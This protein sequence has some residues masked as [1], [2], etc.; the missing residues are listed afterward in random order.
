MTSATVRKARTS[1]QSIEA[2]HQEAERCLRA[3]DSA[4]A[5]RSNA[6]VLSTDPENIIALN[7]QGIIRA[8]Q[9]RLDEAAAAFEQ[10]L[11]VDPTAINAKQ[12]LDQIA[13][14]RAT[15][16]ASIA[17]A[18]DLLRDLTEQA[19][20]ATLDSA[21]ALHVMQE[22][23]SLSKRLAQAN[24]R[25]CI[26]A[27]RI[28]L[29]VQPNLLHGQIDLNNC[30]LKF[31]EKARL[32]DFS[33][34][35][36]P[37]QLGRH[38]LVACF[39]KSGSTLLKRLLCETTGFQEGQYCFAFLQNEQEIYL[40]LVLESA[41]EDRVIQQHCRATVPNLHIL[42]AFE[43]KPIVLVRNIFD[44]LLSWK[45]FL[46]KGAHVNTFFP[47][48]GELTEEQRL[49]LVVDDRA[50]WYL[51]FFAGWQH[52]VTSG[53]IEAT[54]MTYREL[55]ADP[56]A[57]LEGILDFCGI[58][59]DPV[60]VARAT[61]FVNRDTGATRFNKGKVGRG[62]NAFTDAQVEQIRRLASYYTG[63]DFSMIGLEP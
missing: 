19:G 7:R 47:H 31:G 53:Q 40:P 25:E 4:G 58:Q 36:T 45:E 59:A 62:R 50:P 1:S 23:T 43:I 30:L 18:D 22:S 46:D 33:R 55:T 24:R 6:E 17:D 41:T 9:G 51:S 57:A 5:D 63:V 10:A 2:L 52:A 26:D 15:Q 27:L 42:Q 14:I 39:P 11:A 16:Q 34:G 20:R 56:Q 8:M 49:G 29:K 12:N 44:V 13:A 3:K 37:A 54:W 28:A 38:L 60:R 32:E 21:A 35:L 48:Y 61:Q